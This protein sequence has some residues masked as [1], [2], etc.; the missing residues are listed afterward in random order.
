[1]NERG[2]FPWPLAVAGAGLM[3]VSMLTVS[4]RAS[5]VAEGAELRQMVL[6]RASVERQLSALELRFQAL[7]RE[8]GTEARRLSRDGQVS[9]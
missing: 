4:I 7:C 6:R 1:M 5:V 2:G 9:P 3:L 8:L